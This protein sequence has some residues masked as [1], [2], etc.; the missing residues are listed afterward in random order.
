MNYFAIVGDKQCR[1]HAEKTY[2]KGPGVDEIKSFDTVGQF[3]EELKR[4]NH[5][6][7]RVITCELSEEQHEKV[8]EL[9][10]KHATSA[11]VNRHSSVTQTI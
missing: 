6:L 7:V 11:G 5:C 10:K 4:Q 8:K 1:E 3:E 2:G 9:V